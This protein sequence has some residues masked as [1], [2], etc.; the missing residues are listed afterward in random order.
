MSCKSRG[1]RGIGDKPLNCGSCGWIGAVALITRSRQQV[2]V[3]RL[4]GEG[5]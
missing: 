1:G 2:V 3:Y 5:A 4:R